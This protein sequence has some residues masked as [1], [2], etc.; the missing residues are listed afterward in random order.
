MKMKSLNISRFI[1]KRKADLI[2]LVSAMLPLILFAGI[3][4]TNQPTNHDH[5]KGFPPNSGDKVVWVDNG[6]SEAENYSVVEQ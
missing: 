3:W 1:Q 5:D 4:I 2:V 6:D